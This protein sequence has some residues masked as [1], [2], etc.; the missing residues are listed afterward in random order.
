M[1]SSKKTIILPETPDEFVDL[2]FR[3][4]DHIEH[5]PLKWIR[6]CC[7]CSGLRSTLI[8]LASPWTL[9]W[10]QTVT[11]ATVEGATKTPTPFFDLVGGPLRG[12]RIPPKNF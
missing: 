1:S 12:S 8:L 4:R 10:I 9:T 11:L 3:L 6:R 7:T 5:R 2:M